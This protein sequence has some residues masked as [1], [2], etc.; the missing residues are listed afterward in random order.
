MWPFCSTVLGGFREHLFTPSNLYSWGQGDWSFSL[1]RNPSRLEG[2]RRRNKNGAGG[3]GPLQ[4]K[5]HERILGPDAKSPV[6]LHSLRKQSLGIS[7]NVCYRYRE[8]VISSLMTIYLV[9]CKS[10]AK[11]HMLC[12][13]LI[14]QAPGRQQRLPTSG[15]GGVP[16]GLAAEHGLWLHRSLK[17]L[18]YDNAPAKL[19]ISGGKGPT[20]KTHEAE[21][22]V[23]SKTEMGPNPSL[24]LLPEPWQKK[25]VTRVA[26]FRHQYTGLKTE[27]NNPY[28]SARASPAALRRRSGTVGPIPGGTPKAPFC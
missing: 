18:I 3:D 13:P 28:S 19:L 1:A 23:N 8:P 17:Y 21:G 2:Y 16:G 7:V 5:P 6:K 14:R 15:S 24:L 20:A 25:D 9:F 27:V 22:L 11:Y 26:F 12:R 10:K 4:S